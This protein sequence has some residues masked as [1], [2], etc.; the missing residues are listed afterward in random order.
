MAPL[1]EPHVYGDNALGLAGIHYSADAFISS[2]Q[3]NAQYQ[4]ADNLEYGNDN[5]DLPPITSDAFLPCLVQYSDIEVTDP[6]YNFPAC[7]PQPDLAAPYDGGF[8]SDAN[9]LY[10]GDWMS[11]S[12]LLGSAF[13]THP[14]IANMDPAGTAFSAAWVPHQTSQPID[15]GLSTWNPTND[16]F[17]H[18]TT[19]ASS[20]GLSHLQQ[21]VLSPSWTDYGFSSTARDASRWIYD[22]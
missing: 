9:L 17:N 15:A 22:N 7:D 1:A 20:W 2:S 3:E 14:S 13:A 10:T 12:S 11:P 8:N 19:D 18:S 21:Q 4:I 5:F 16:S 6:V